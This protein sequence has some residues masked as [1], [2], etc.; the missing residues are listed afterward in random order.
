MLD[1]SPPRFIVAARE[2]RLVPLDESATP[3]PSRPRKAANPKSDWGEGPSYG[4][5]VL[6]S[7]ETGF[8][9]SRGPWNQLSFVNSPLT[10]LHNKQELLAQ[11]FFIPLTTIVINKRFP[12][13]FGLG[14]LWS[15]P[16]D[17][18]RGSKSPLTKI[19]TGDGLLSTIR[20]QRV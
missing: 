1:K 20:T 13:I 8:K 19:E 14:G 16:V 11:S 17:V 7:A 6:A 18:E 10:I 12:S 4:V 2:L 15:L 9:N 3:G 5:K